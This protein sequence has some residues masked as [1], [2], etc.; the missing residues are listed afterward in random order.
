VTAKKKPSI[1]K[2]P[3]VGRR[4]Q[5]IARALVKKLVHRYKL[6]AKTR[7]PIAL[8]AKTSLAPGKPRRR[9][10]KTRRSRTP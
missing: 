5:D 2:S 7:A 4:V 3:Q 6:D 9:T 10:N 8:S 1:K